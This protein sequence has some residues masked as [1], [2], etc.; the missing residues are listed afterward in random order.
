MQ[1]SRELEIDHE[2]RIYRLQIQVKTLILT[3]KPS[4]ISQVASQSGFSQSDPVSHQRGKH[5]VDSL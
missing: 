5:C 1:S 3:A 4:L 2:G